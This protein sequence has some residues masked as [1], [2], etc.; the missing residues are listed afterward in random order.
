MLDQIIPQARSFEHTLDFDQPVINIGSHPE[1]DI[2]LTGPGV[3]PF[4][5]LVIIEA[6][7]QK[8]VPLADDAEIRVNGVLM[9]ESDL[10][11]TRNQAVEIGGYT[12]HFYENGGAPGIHV[13]IASSNGGNA[14]LP[15]RFFMD[16][17]DVAILVNVLSQDAEVEVEQSAVFE[18]EVVNAGPIVA[19]FHMSLQGVPPDWVEIQNGVFNLNEGGRARVNVRVT[20]RREPASTAGIHN[21]SINVSSPNYPG[22][23]VEIPFEL[24][25]LPYY[26]F[27]LGNLSPKQQRISWRK[28][29]GLVHLPITNRGNSSAD[30]LV[31]AIDEENGCSFDFHINE[32]LRLTRQATV[33]IPAGGKLDLPIEITP[34]KQALFALRSKRYHFT[35]TAQIS[36]QIASPQTISASVTS[37]PLFGW[38]SIMLGILTI[39][40]GLFILLQPRIQ[41]FQLVAG[42]DVIELGDTTKLEWSVSPFV[43]RLSI[44]NIDQP[45]NRVQKSL[46]IAPG[47]STTYELVAGNWLSGMLG[48]DRRESQ[49]VLV[50]PLSPEI[51]VFEVD[52][53]TV[54]KGTPVILR[55]SVTQADQ[56]FLTVDEVVYE[57]PPDQFSGEQEFMLEKDALLTLEAVSASGSELRSYFVNVVPPHIT[58]NAFTIWVRA[59]ATA[60]NL[61][62]VPSK[63]GG[64][65]LASQM[66]IPDANFPEEYVTLIPDQSSDSGYRVEFLQP[67]RE[68]AKGE[69]VMLEW[70]VEGVEKVQ[71]AP[72]TEELPNRGVQPFFPQ[73]SMNFVMTAQSGELEQIYMLPVKVFDGTPPEA[74]KIEFFKASPLKM[75]GAGPVE[76]AWSVSGEWT[77]VQLA[78]GESVIADYL[79]PQ[80]FKTVTVSK[81][82]TFILTAWNGPDLSSAAPVEITV[83]PALKAVDLIITRISPE[84]QTFFKVGEYVDVFIDFLDPKTGERPNPYPSG[85]VTV[86]DSHAV[87][88]IKLPTQNCELIFNAAGV[89]TGDE[90]IR[91]YYSGDSIYLPAESEIFTDRSIIVEANEVTLNPVY[92]HIN[93]TG[94]KSTQINDLSNPTP[95]LKVGRG[96]L[97][98]V[99]VN[100][101]NQPLDPND[102]KAK[103]T[104]RYCPFVNNVIQEQDCKTQLPKTVEVQDPTLGIAEIVIPYF[105]EAGTYALLISY[106][107][108][109]GA[110]EPVSLGTDGSIVFTIELGQLALIPVGIDPCNMTQCTLIQGEDHY[111]FDAV[112]VIENDWLVPLNSTYPKPNPLT[113]KLDYGTVDPVYWTDKCEW[114][115]SGDHW[116]YFCDQIS[117]D[118]QA[119]L[120][121]DFQTSDPNYY[122][123]PAPMVLNLTVKLATVLAFPN[124][125]NFLNGNYVGTTLALQ[126]SNV[127]LQ[128]NGNPITGTIKLTLQ[129][130]GQDLTSLSKYIVI[131][132][133]STNCVPPTGAVL[134]IIQDST[135]TESCK[136]AF[137]KA[138][139]YTLLFSYDGDGT[140]NGAT[141]EKPSEIAE[142]TGIKAT[143][144]PASPYTWEIFATKAVNLTFSCPTSTPS[145]ANFDLNVLKEAKL[146]VELANAPGCNVSQGTLPLTDGKFTLSSTSAALSFRCTELGVKQLRLAFIDPSDGD[147]SLDSGGGPIALEIVPTPKTTQPEIRIDTGSN[148][149]L[150]GDP[151]DNISNTEWWVGETYWVIVKLTS[152]P[153]DANVFQ[154]KVQMEW[155]LALTNVLS[156]DS[157]KT[158]CPTPTTVGTDKSV[159]DLLLQKST[160][161]NTIWE[162]KCKFTF[163]STA[164]LVNNDTIDFELV[165]AR[166]TEQATDL[167]VDLP[168][169]V[170]KRTP[171]INITAP[172]GTIYTL[173]DPKFQIEITDSHYQLDAIATWSNDVSITIDGNNLPLSACTRNG[174]TLDCNLP[175]DAAWSGDIF[176][177]YA[178]NATFKRVEKTLANVSVVENPLKLTSVDGNFPEVIQ[179]ETCAAGD[180]F[181]NPTFYAFKNSDYTL[182][183]IV[184]SE[185]GAAVNKG[186]IVVT[187]KHAEIR[188][189]DVTFTS[190]GVVESCT[191]A[192]G[193]HCDY[194]IPVT[195]NQATFSWRPIKVFSSDVK[196]SYGYTDASQTFIQSTD[197]NNGWVAATNSRWRNRA[198]FSVDT[199]YRTADSRYHLKINELPATSVFKFYLEVKGCTTTPNPS[200]I[201]CEGNSASCWDGSIT[202]GGD[203]SSVDS[204][205]VTDPNWARLV[206][207]DFGCKYQIILTDISIAT[208]YFGWEHSDGWP[209]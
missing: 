40:L 168:G 188:A 97:I 114:Q 152:M 42:K 166:F 167:T 146:Q 47:Q 43:T 126:P 172:S 86:S 99:Y 49:T 183:F 207:T 123:A 195:S 10:T 193:W 102:D 131:S 37:L 206:G 23:E 104:V 133:S 17:V 36:Q 29:T 15:S 75:L 32:E 2:T 154:D 84:Q 64:G 124:G 181:Y 111:T 94:E 116:E 110:F 117:L 162:T 90:G 79:N 85:E 202:V 177:V 11:L 119:T 169:G 56:V 5:A 139:N 109:D 185:T 52:R 4:H 174:Y 28:R 147:F 120:E 132:A 173:T 58:V 125:D 25:I 140:Y 53:T 180:E 165:S 121:Y 187:F 26:E 92:Y 1:N 197:V 159:F 200:P 74:P 201:T 78:S 95:A 186:N 108:S 208:L 48:L 153:A 130:D 54:D 73:E 87:C 122:I 105:P 24:T 191:S 22:H 55:W 203:S 77:R 7:Q 93:K 63:S 190:S 70:D 68:L 46:T 128:S 8:L 45:I 150:I 118:D 209:P 21:I 57:L 142:Q 35:T 61:P 82:S 184:E 175:D 170:I 155:P 161:D 136:I 80:G 88:T 135:P 144:S 9:D 51:G 196:Y 60:A 27:G 112:L 189:G 76:F 38:W 50:I 91:A 18:L 204:K 13:S 149:D 12:L 157:A 16:P 31:S 39:L 81:S 182:T 3:L 179:C 98:D 89:K 83:D 19:S 158:T 134:E 127:E 145:C 113:M 141:A 205:V 34:L 198:Q 96:L 171:V 199:W 156:S 41:Y 20:P 164:T 69:Q 65:Y 6:N 33:S 44:S 101:V 178:E 66:F 137:K 115:I 163:A 129:K 72:F 106:Q 71:I 148:L 143:W 194:K 67:D 103:I 107:H 192:G 176:V 62:V 138:G 151:G 30:F 100:P 14:P 59:A 160:S